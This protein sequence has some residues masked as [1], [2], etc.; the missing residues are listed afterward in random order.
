MTISVLL[1]LFMS[2]ENFSCPLLSSVVSLQFVSLWCVSPAL[3]L[4]SPFSSPPRRPSLA[5][6]GS[7]SSSLCPQAKCKSRTS[8]YLQKNR[9]GYSHTKTANWVHS[10]NTSYLTQIY[11]THSRK[12]HEYEYGR[13]ML[14]AK[15]KKN[16]QV[17]SVTTQTCARSP[18]Y[19][20]SQVNAA[21]SNLFITSPTPLVGWA[22]MGL[23]GT[24]GRDKGWCEHL[25]EAK[26]HTQTNTAQ[27]ISIDNQ[28][29][30]CE[31]ILFCL[32]QRS[33]CE[34]AFR[35]GKEG[36]DV[37]RPL[38][39]LRFFPWHIL[40]WKTNIT[41]KTVCVTKIPLEYVVLAPI[42]LR[43][44]GSVTHTSLSC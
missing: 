11:K 26:I 29:L 8:V 38:V 6:N 36:E 42:W 17:L 39:M 19:L 16:K 25:E 35:L 37:F 21:S 10:G 3:A 14:G 32:T 34:K 13:H 7:S 18:S 23:S 4:I 12:V 15:R 22:N 20:Y 40:T 1:C 30:Y 43:K 24:P 5:I 41:P 9:H 2:P 33:W 44:Q 27:C 31:L 28:R